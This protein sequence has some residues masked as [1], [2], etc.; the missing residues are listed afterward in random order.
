MVLKVACLWYG[1]RKEDLGS[2]REIYSLVMDKKIS[3]FQEKN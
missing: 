1:S 3:A 2:F